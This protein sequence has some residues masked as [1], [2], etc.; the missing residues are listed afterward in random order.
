MISHNQTNV[1]VRPK[2]L[3][4]KKKTALAGYLFI[5]PFFILFAIFGAFPMVF[6]FYLAFQK[7]N[8]FGDMTFVGFNNFSFIF[9][10]PLFWKS[11][12]NTIVIG[13]LGTGPQ[14]IAALILAVALNSAIVKFKSVFRVAYFVPNVTSIVAVAIVFTVLFSEQE[15]GLVNATLRL[16]GISPVSWQTS[17]W[18]AKIAIATMIFWRWV[19]YNSI[20]FLAGLQSIPKDLYEAAE[21]D[22]A[23]KWQQFLFITVPMLKPIIVFVVFTA[24]IGS[25]QIFAEP[26]I[27]GSGFREE[28]MTIVLYLWREAFSNNAFGTASATAVSLFLLIIVFTTINFFAS[29]RLDKSGK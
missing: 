21:I 23:K 15:A 1:A 22:G 18:G 26:L 6:S 16:F 28:S 14:L 8:G 24:T 9:T 19:G 3:S 13:L 11:I 17:E 4:D 29:N 25:L 7:W 2:G 12:Y 27:F 5:S 20:I 10:D